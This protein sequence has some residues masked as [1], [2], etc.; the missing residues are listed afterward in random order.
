MLAVATPT[1][2]A[3]PAAWAAAGCLGDAPVHGQVLKF[4]AE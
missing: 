2:P 4:L 3:D 1:L